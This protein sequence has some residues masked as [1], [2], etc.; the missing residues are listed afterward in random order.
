MS[1]S[2]NDVFDVLVD[3]TCLFYT[4]LCVFDSVALLS[5]SSDSLFSSTGD[6][7]MSFKNLWAMIDVLHLPP[8]AFVSQGILGLRHLAGSVGA[9]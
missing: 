9:D 4:L 2:I 8:L 7:F 1:K 6:P 5:P 3:V